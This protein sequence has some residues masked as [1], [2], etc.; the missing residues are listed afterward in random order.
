MKLKYIPNP[1]RKEFSGRHI[2]VIAK[3]LRRIQ[4]ECSVITPRNVVLEAADLRSPL[5]PFF[6]WNNSKAADKF[7][8]WQARH[9]ILNVYM[10]DESDE[11]SQPIR[12]FVN[13]QVEDDDPGFISDRGY[14][15]ITGVAGKQS[16]ETQLLDYAQDQLLRWKQRFGNYRQFFLVVQAIE[17]TVKRKK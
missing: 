7:R 16:Y 9:L 8:L 14:V 10:I 2:K 6:E 3:E 11:N 12:A 17:K 5:H 1:N 13:L 4:S 15:A